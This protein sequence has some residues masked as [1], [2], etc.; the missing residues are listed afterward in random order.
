MPSKNYIL[1][2][3]LE[4]GKVFFTIQA[5]QG[6]LIYQISKLHPIQL[7]DLNNELA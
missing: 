5:V 3:N 6:D 1:T 7:L 2:Y 4:P